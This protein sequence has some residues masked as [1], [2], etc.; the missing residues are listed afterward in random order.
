MSRAIWLRA[1]P[2]PA[3][4]PAAAAG[5]EL[6]AAAEPPDFPSAKPCTSSAVIVPSGPVPRTSEMSTPRSFARRRA[7]GEIYAVAAGVAAAVVGFSWAGAD[8]AAL[9]ATVVAR[10]LGA[11]VIVDLAG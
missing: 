1:S 5:A 10:A 11:A 9:G 2:P 4:A 6:A 7:F 3:V 8:E